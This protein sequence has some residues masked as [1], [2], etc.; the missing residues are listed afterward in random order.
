[1]FSVWLN[2]NSVSND[3]ENYS[4]FLVA[5][6]I[7]F[8]V[9]DQLVNDSWQLVENEAPAIVHCRLSSNPSALSTIEWLKNDQLLIGKFSVC[10]HFFVELEILFRSTAKSTD[11]PLVVG[12]TC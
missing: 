9:N 2:G 6:M 12:E 1:M 4:P 10:F 5:P 7:D 8:F 3:D 11:D